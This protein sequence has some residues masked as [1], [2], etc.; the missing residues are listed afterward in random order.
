VPHFGIGITPTF[1][2]PTWVTNFFTSEPAV[3]VIAAL[4]S[5]HFC[6]P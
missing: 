4:P 1:D 6:W 2:T 3:T 5:D